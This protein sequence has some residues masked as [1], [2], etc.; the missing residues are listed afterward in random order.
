M[1]LKSIF[2]YPR[3]AA[4]LGQLHVI[5]HNIWSTWDYEAKRLFRRIDPEM[6]EAVAG[7]PVELLLRVPRDRMDRLAADGD[8]SNQ[9]DKVARRFQQYIENGRGTDWSD[10]I[11]YFSLEFGLHQCL[12][13]Y[14]GGLGILAGD[15]LKEASDMGLPVVGIGLLYKL[16]YFTQRVNPEGCQEELLNKFDQHLCPVIRIRDEAGRPAFVKLCLPDGEATIGLWQIEVG[17]SKLVLLDT[18]NEENPPHFRAITGQL[19]VSDREKRLQ[20]ELVLGI[21]GVKALEKIGIKPKIYHA[22]EGHSSFLVIPRLQRLM[23]GEKLS[24][25]QARAIIRS[26]TVFTTHTPVLAGNENFETNLLRRY[27]EPYAR[28]LGMSFEQLGEWGFVD[29]NRDVFWLPAF[30]I[31]FSGYVNG[32]SRLHRDVSRNMWSRIYPNTPKA[33]VPIGFVTNGVH[34]SWLSEPFAGLLGPFADPGDH[35]TEEDFRRHVMNIPDGRIW[36]AHLENKRRLIEFIRARLARGYLLRGHPLEKMENVHGVLN[37]DFLTISFAKRFAYYKRPTLIL[38]DPERLRR[39]LTNPER[40]AQLIFAGKAHPADVA[41]KKMIKQIIDF[42]KEY[43]LED[44]LV[45]LEN[46]D[47]AA[48]R[49]LVAGSDLWLNT[50]VVENEASGTSGMK[51]AING[52]LNLSV[53]DGWWPEGYNGKNGWAIEPDRFAGHHQLKEI[54][55]ANEIYDLLEGPVAQLY[56]QRDEQGV[57]VNWVGRMKEAICSVY[58]KFSMNRVLSDYMKSLYA[59]A[60]AEFDSLSEENHRDLSGISGMEQ[61]IRNNWDSI[62]FVGFQ[63]NVDGHRHLVESDRLEVTCSVDFGR[64][65]SD[66]FRVEL[67]YLIGADSFKAIPMERQQPHE[68]PAVYRACF[69]I[70]GYGQQNINARIRPASDILHGLYPDLIKWRD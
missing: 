62:R 17:R 66:L 28:S 63:T 32:V 50:P 55:E 34:R 21:G 52:L 4:K 46:Y 60:R 6:F 69:K 41:G 25:A 10:P 49:R 31:R 15:F 54:T 64:A 57:P 61:Q 65:P 23:H 67:F 27:I 37:D 13:L 16:G 24:F 44:R 1:A 51:A 36:Q 33:E 42:A 26:S 35:G 40:P 8:F 11:A 30:A 70:E 20:Q 68:N 48:G 5:A 39:I 19:Y 43:R 29:Q 7:N 53:L 59:P 38:K 14:G 45:F 12:P 47:M 9:L 18:D 2:V 58:L 3:H 56:Y 22:N